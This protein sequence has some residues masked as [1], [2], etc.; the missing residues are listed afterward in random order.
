M[1]WSVW[2]FVP[3]FLWTI[4]S[5]IG[6]L[7]GVMVWGCFIGFSVLDMQDNLGCLESRVHMLWPRL[8]TTEVLVDVS[9]ANLYWL[10][11]PRWFVLVNWS[12]ITEACC[13]GYILVVI[14]WALTVD[15]CSRL[16]GTDGCAVNIL[17][18]PKFRPFTHILLLL[19]TFLFVYHIGYMLLS[20]YFF[21]TGIIDMGWC[22]IFSFPVL[23][24][25]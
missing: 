25:L 20:V 8:V 5:P 21:E 16:I 4:W 24:M 15:F 18:L 17:L 3:L 14:R 7:N 11:H 2:L 12:K 13:L 10:S 9:V 6:R 22:G 23:C 1:K 19:L